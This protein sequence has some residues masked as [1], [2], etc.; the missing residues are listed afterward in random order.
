MIYN[1]YT[2]QACMISDTEYP[3]LTHFLSKRWSRVGRRSMKYFHSFAESSFCTVTLYH[4]VID[5]V[6]GVFTFLLVLLVLYRVYI[7]SYLS[8]FETEMIIITE[9]LFPHH[10]ICQT[11]ATTFQKN[12][13]HKCISYSVFFLVFRYKHVDVLKSRHGFTWEA[14]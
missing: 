7:R 9:E 5:L 4:S 6:T 3:H 2:L 14:K 13:R 10:C 1:L 11:T 8:S 12:I